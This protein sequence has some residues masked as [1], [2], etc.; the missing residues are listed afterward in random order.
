MTCEDLGLPFHKT[1]YKHGN[2][3]ITFNIKFPEQMNANQI[4]AA[5]TILSSQQKSTADK[6]EFENASEKVTLM[7]F[8]EHHKNTHAQG[9]TRAHGS[10]EEEDEEGEGVKV[11]CNQQ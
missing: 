11:G 1:P 10:D 8:Q 9:G 6:K 2:L 4:E 3:F 7:K 5:N